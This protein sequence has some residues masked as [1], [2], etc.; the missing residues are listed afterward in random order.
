MCAESEQIRVLLSDDA[1]LVR[2]GIRL[3]LEKIPDVEVIGETSDHWE[4][5]GLILK[6]R[7][8][9]LIVQP[10]LDSSWLKFAA[11]IKAHFP[12]LRLILLG[13]IARAIE[14][15]NAL[16]SGFSGY[17]SLTT[18]AEEV[19]FAIKAVAKGETY[20]GEEGRKHLADL[21][22]LESL[23]ARQREILAMIAQSRST[24]QIG[25]VLKISHK[26]VETHRA[27]LTEKLGIHD[28]A[29]L[30]RYAITVGLVDKPS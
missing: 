6:N 17:L 26:T 1:G 27:H 10:T 30:V 23:T 4:L 12:A 19:E 8:D 7:P 14:L 9:I 5:L 15:Q 28:I 11:A 13:T 18:Y 25:Y 3:V 2:C 21:K 22:L 29:G 24:K 16:T 20:L